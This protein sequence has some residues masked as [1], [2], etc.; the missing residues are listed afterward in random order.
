LLKVDIEKGAQIASA[1]EAQIEV[2][3]AAD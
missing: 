3:R 2:L 1:E